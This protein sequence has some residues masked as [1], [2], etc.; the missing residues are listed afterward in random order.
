MEPD[1]HNLCVGLREI[2]QEGRGIALIQIYIL[3][4]KHINSFREDELIY[5]KNVKIIIYNTS[6]ELYCVVRWHLL[7]ICQTRHS[8]VCV[9]YINLQDQQ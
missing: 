5:N 1:S 9:P 4:Y 8:S 2:N 3:W 7:L 6:L